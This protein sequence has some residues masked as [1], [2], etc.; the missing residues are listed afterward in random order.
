MTGSVN[1]GDLL[2][3]GL[4][5]LVLVV[6]VLAA[7]LLLVP[8][9]LVSVGFGAILGVVGGLGTQSAEGG[10]AQFAVS[11][12]MSGDTDAPIAMSAPS[13]ANVTD[14]PYAPELIA[15]A[16]TWI[17]TRYVFGG[18]SPSGIDCSCFVQTVFRSVGIGLPR[19]SQL[20]YNATVGRGLGTGDPVPGD[21]VFFFR[22]YFDVGQDWT[23]VG[24]VSRVNADGSVWM[25]DAPGARAASDPPDAPFGQV[26]EEPITGSWVQHRPTYARIPPPPSPTNR[27]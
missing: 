16:R 8:I 1:S 27:G 11:Q 17:G 10:I 3:V 13:G 20:Q 19:T 9:G 26:R 25:I 7:V 5:R 6:W 14:L 15:L 12:R 4:G 22:T 24:V 21:L 23:H 2:G 18:C